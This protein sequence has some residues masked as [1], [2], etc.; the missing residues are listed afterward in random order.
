MDTTLN[1]RTFL[2]AC[3]FAA[4]GCRTPGNL[5]VRESD[6]VLH[7]RGMAEVFQTADGIQVAYP[8]PFAAV[9]TLVVGEGKESVPAAEVEILDQQPDHF[10]FRWKRDG[11]LAALSWRAEGPP[12]AVPP[13]GR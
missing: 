8:R 10:R 4:A 13:G 1:R 11:G 9:P 12:A 6:G 7:Q 3:G 5:M 2:A